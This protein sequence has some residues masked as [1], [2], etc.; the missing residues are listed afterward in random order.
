MTLKN[1]TDYKNEGTI[2]ELSG[3]LSFKSSLP[4]KKESVGLF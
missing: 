2:N 3:V 4:M 1:T